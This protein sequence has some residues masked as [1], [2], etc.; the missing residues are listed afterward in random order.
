MDVLKVCP[1]MEVLH[2]CGCLECV[3][4]LPR[5]AFLV[6]VPALWHERGRKG[7]SD[8]ES[9][10]LGLTLTYCINFFLIIP[11]DR[12]VALFRYFGTFSRAVLAIIGKSGCLNLILY[13][14][15][16]SRSRTPARRR[17]RAA[18]SGLS[19]IRA[20]H[21]VFP[22]SACKLREKK[23]SGKKITEMGMI[24]RELWD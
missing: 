4:T 23:R 11:Y 5:R 7:A 1:P 10:H 20:F 9:S 14:N 13:D 19:S 16:I 24:S 3:D 22:L 17:G 2:F 12:Y 8:V 6:F 18:G 15:A 21:F